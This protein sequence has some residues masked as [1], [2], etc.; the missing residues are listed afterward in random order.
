[1]PWRL[2]RRRFCKTQIELAGR[3]EAIDYGVRTAGTAS[4]AVIELD[5]AGAASDT[6]GGRTK[7]LRG[8][9]T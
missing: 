8:I 7:P 1:M 9:G 6:N 5:Y 4:E 2:R 3:L